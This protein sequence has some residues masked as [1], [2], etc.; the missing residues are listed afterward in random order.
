MAKLTAR[1]E[2]RNLAGLGITNFFVGLPTLGKKPY[3]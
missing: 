3:L 1:T 2:Q